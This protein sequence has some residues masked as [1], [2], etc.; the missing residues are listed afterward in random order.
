MTAP[1]VVNLPDL[2]G[3]TPW[4]AYVEQDDLK[5]MVF[6]VPED[7]KYWF[8]CL[9]YRCSGDAPTGGDEN[10]ESWPIWPVLPAHLAEDLTFWLGHEGL[11]PCS[12]LE[13]RAAPPCT[14]VRPR[15]DQ[16]PFDDWDPW[17]EV[18]AVPPW[19]EARADPEE[20]R[21]P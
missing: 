18:R 12:H 9:R 14:R 16:T 4:F 3:V 1:A 2:D 6:L 10:V 5:A 15:R 8:V 13:W 7:G 21:L 20:E 17:I 11:C 19:D